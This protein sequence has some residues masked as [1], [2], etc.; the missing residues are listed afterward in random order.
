MGRR[1]LS[2]L[3]P[4]VQI[5]HAHLVCVAHNDRYR[6]QLDEHAAQAVRVPALNLKPLDDVNAESAVSM[7]FAKL[8]P[9]H[10]AMPF[11]A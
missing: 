8:Q 7:N 11:A 1:G 3:L 10:S 9:P 4:A 6:P 5:E 2:P